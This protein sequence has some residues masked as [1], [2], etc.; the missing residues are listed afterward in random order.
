MAFAPVGLDL[1]P[2]VTFLP[3]GFS[4]NGFDTNPALSLSDPKNWR[5][6]GLAAGFNLTR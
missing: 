4:E 2:G 5:F 6:T 1:A 3:K